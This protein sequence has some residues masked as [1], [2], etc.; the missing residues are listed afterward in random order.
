MRP[1]FVIGSYIMSI[2]LD[3]V[4]SAQSPLRVEKIQKTRKS[5]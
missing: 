3:V 4:E 2:R 1:K 5:D